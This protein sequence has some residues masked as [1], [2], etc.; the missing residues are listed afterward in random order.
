MATLDGVR[1][2]GTVCNAQQSSDNTPNPLI[3]CLTHGQAIGLAVGIFSCLAFI[4]L[5]P[6]T[7]HNRSVVPEFCFCARHI[8][9]DWR[10]PGFPL[11]VFPNSRNVAQWNVRWYRRNV[12][13]SN[14][15]LFQRPTDIYMVCLMAFHMPFTAL[16]LCIN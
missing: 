7:A 4:E 12:P 8:R 14:W 1:V 10:K 13:R 11:R 3:S 9:L 16:H 15:R 5:I 6:L 2:S